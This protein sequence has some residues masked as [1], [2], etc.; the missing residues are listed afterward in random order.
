MEKSLAGRVPTSAA[1]VPS[2]PQRGPLVITAVSGLALFVL[3]FAE[4]PEGPAIG[5]ATAAQVREFVAAHEVA[6]RIGATGGVLAVVALLVFTGGL[7]AVVRGV[8][9]RSVLPGLVAAGGVAVALVQLLNTAALTVTGLLP[10]LVD[11][12]LAEIDDAT[13]VG[14]YELGGF[15]HV[16]GDFHMALIAV[17]VLA[18]S[19][20]VVRYRILP[21]WIGWAGA[22]IGTAA[23][24]G[25]VGVTLGVP[26]LYPLWFVGLFGWLLWI[27]AVGVAC[28]AR[29]RRGGASPTA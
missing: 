4:P 21:R 1:D 28:L 5:R 24:V 13:V 26:A 20:A 3:A 29:G 12:T 14:W 11:T 25:T 9:P 22:G 17:V 19:L 16:L 10:G 27:L 2:A 15:T 23:A 6:L 18:G 8:A 7:A